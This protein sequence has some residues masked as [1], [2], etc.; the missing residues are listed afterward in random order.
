MRKA[1][2]AF[3]ALM[4]VAN[5][6]PLS[7]AQIKAAIIQESI[8]AYPGTCPCPYNVDRR[9][10]SCG[11]RSAYSRPDGYAPICYAEQVTAGMIHDY[12]NSHNR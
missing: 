11:R 8:A 5:S 10:H 4:S 6:A 12:R 7:D 1:A 3:F 9:G 2:I